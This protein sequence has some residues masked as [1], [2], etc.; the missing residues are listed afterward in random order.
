MSTWARKL[1][2]A[3]A[4][5]FFAS[6]PAPAQAD[7][8]QLTVQVST[9]QAVYS[10]GD[11]VEIDVIQ[12]NPTLSPISVTYNCPCCHDRVTVLDTEGNLV[13]ESDGGCTQ[14]VGVVSW[15][16][17]ECLSEAYTWEQLAPYFTEGSQV[18]PGGYSVRHHWQFADFSRETTS[19]PFLLGTPVEV[20]TLSFAGVVLLVAMILAVGVRLLRLG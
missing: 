6:L 10:L 1:S 18:A 20:P 16:P 4:A 2:L 7:V 3:L 11:E 5:S 8:S 19:G 12:C 15:A 13:S 9:S 17:G 14:V